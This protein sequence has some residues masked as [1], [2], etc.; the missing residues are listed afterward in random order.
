MSLP[1]VT[2]LPKIRVAVQRVESP[3]VSRLERGIPVA[4]ETE[5]TPVLHSGR[6]RGCHP[7]R[8]TGNPFDWGEGGECNLLFV[9]YC[10]LG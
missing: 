9:T 2:D 5:D 8:E 1:V 3:S 10:P 7:K 6:G 4:V